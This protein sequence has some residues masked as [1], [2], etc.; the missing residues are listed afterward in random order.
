MSVTALSSRALVLGVPALVASILLLVGQANAAPLQSPAAPP[1]SVAAFQAE[2]GL[3]EELATQ[4]TDAVG[5]GIT[6]LFGMGVLGA[7]KWIYTAQDLRGSL[8]W[9]QQPWFWTPLLLLVGVSVIGDRIPVVKRFLR[10]WKLWENKFAAALSIPVVATMAVAMIDAA[11]AHQA[12]PTAPT[13]SAQPGTGVLASAPSASFALLTAVASVAAM[14]VVLVM[15]NALDVLILLSPFT[16]VDWILKLCKFVPLVIMVLAARGS[17]WLGAAVALA[18]LLV[19]ILLFGWSM[20]LTIMG[21]VF[22]RDILFR[23]WRRVPDVARGFRAFARSGLPGVAVRTYGHVARSEGRVSFRCR[24]LFVGPMRDVPLPPGE[25]VIERGLL[26]GPDVAVRAPGDARV[27]AYAW[28]APAIRSH[29]ELLGQ[30]LRAAEIRDCA[31]V[32]G[33]RGIWSWMKGL[34]RGAAPVEAPVAV[35][36]GSAGSEGAAASRVPGDPR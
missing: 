11:L 5:I 9:Y 32:R 29:E 36:A 28:C 13:A 7:W 21:S 6:P 35:A 2:Y 24:R 16:V 14:L 19:C 27:R 8:P 12:A 10:A 26:F 30:H 20:R 23:R 22:A 1:P 25:I 3:G 18:I 17:P 34:L 31:L 4:L 33:I 15:K